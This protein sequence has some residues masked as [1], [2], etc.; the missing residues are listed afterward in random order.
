MVWADFGCS[1]LGRREFPRFRQ[2]IPDDAVC[3]GEQ[4][5]RV[6]LMDQ[7]QTPWQN[8]ISNS[9]SR[10]NGQELWRKP[11]FPTDSL[12]RLRWGIV[13][14]TPVGAATAAFRFWVMNSRLSA[15]KQEQSSSG[16]DWRFSSNLTSGVLSSVCVGR[17]KSS[18]GDQLAAFRPSEQTSLLDRTFSARFVSFVFEVHHSW[19][20]RRQFSQSVFMNTPNRP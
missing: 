7:K 19:L 10:L 13:L 14:S 8:A 3:P 15:D 9:P 17:A 16:T 18:V 20:L 6:D 4:V 2:H 11:G 12:R 5:I 1:I